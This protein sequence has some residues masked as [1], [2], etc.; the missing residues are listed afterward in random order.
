MTKSLEVFDPAMCCS[1]G[2]CGPSTD[3]DLIR[4][5]ADLDWL[6][7]HGTKVRRYNLSQEPEAFISNPQVAEALKGGVGCLPLIL[8]E[9]QIISQGAYLTKEALVK[10]VGLPA[11][12]G[13]IAIPIIAK[14]CS[15]S[16]C[17]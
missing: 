5:A 8:V 12:K 13:K 15:G 10:H 9:G 4:F 16:H 6:E 1:T 3:P 7:R 2:V 11:D 17:C 14:S